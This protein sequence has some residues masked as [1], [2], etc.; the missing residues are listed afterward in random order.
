M[1]NEHLLTEWY[2]RYCYPCLDAAH[3]DTEEKCLACFDLTGLPVDGVRPEPTTEELLRQ[4][5]M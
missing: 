1:N 5:Y 4:Y 2:L 3:C